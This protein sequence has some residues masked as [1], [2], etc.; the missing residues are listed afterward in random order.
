MNDLSQLQQENYHEFLKFVKSN[1]DPHANQW[2]KE[3]CIPKSIIELCSKAGYLGGSLP[4]K[5]GGQGWDCLTYGMFSEAIAKSSTSLGGLFNVHTMIEQTILRWGT[6]EQKQRWLLPMAEGEIIGAF[7]L[8]EPESGSDI[9]S[10]TTEYKLSGEKIILN[11]KK[12]WITFGA[13][14]DIILV[15]GKLDGKAVACLVEKKTP[16]LKITP[17]KDMLGFKAGHLAELHFDNCVVK[18]ENMIGREGS[19]L[20][21]IAL[22]ALEFGR[23]NVAF[24]ALGILR[25]CLEACSQHVLK[26]KSF[27]KCLMDHGAI[28]KMIADMGV[29]Y[30][31]ARL[32]CINSTIA[33]NENLPDASEKI[34]IAKYFTTMAAARHSGN[35]VQVMGALGCHENCSVSRYYRDS[36][37]LEIIE[38]SNEIHQMLLGKSFARQFAKN[39]KNIK[40]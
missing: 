19:A 32:L 17:I 36:K 30:E 38:G 24:A 6:D 21:Y 39:R 31:S 35:A 12:R 40:A 16:G 10:I 5:Y 18:K 28:R 3:E 11:G 4:L 13:L 1:I 25:G 15:F 33:K 34:M 7:A 14:A 22:S 9:S 2:E 26:R 8:T 37:M 27:G 23:I 20:I 29:D